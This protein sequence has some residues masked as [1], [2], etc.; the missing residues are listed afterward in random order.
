MGGLFRSL[1]GVFV[2]YFIDGGKYLRL[3]EVDLL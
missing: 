2:S 3:F 1:A